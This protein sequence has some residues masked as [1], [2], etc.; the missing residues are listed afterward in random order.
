M[1]DEKVPVQSTNIPYHLEQMLDILRHE[2]DDQNGGATV[3][4]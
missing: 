2:E 3:I 4:F 1:A